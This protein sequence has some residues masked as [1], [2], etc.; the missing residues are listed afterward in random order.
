MKKPT[1][2]AKKPPRPK[3]LPGHY[4]AIAAGEEGHPVDL[5]VEREV[6]D[7]ETRRRALALQNSVLA[8]LG[9]ET[10]RA[11][12]ELEELRNEIAADREERY[13]DVGYERGLAEARSR[14]HRPARPLPP[15]AAHVLEDIR[16]RVL[17]TRPT[18]DALLALV[19]CLHELV[20][21]SAPGSRRA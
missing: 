12:L 16:E 20:L 10:R 17:D 3:R 13:F 5:L 6:G 18:R 14:M 8:E 11:F 7:E 21:L 4:D 15:G 19:E 9:P 2:S 1:R